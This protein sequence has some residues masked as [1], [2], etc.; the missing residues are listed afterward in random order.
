MAVGASHPVPSSS[1][2]AGA[3]S[4]GANVLAGVGDAEVGTTTA[5]GLLG[6]GS[7]AA[8]VGDGIGEGVGRG[9]GV[10]AADG[11]GREDA[12][13]VGDGAGRAFVGDGR[14]EATARITNRVPCCGAPW[15]WQKSV[16]V[17]T[18]VSTGVV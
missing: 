10:G 17:P 11:E 14:G 3:T 4:G 16:K 18:L 13:C 12:R 9:L 1:A 5:R 2:T 8:A 6:D 15:T 7:A